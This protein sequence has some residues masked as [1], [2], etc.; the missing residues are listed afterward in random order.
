MIPLIADHI[1]Y[2]IQRV[3]G[4][5]VVWNE[6]MSRARA[7]MDIDLTE[8]DYRNNMRPRRMERYRVPDYKAQAPAIFHSSYFRVLPQEGVRNVTTVHD[9]TYHFYRR[10]LAKAVHLWEE[11]RAL[12]HSDAV[13]CV[14]ENTKRDVLRFYPWVDEEKVH[15][16]YN[17]VSDDFFPISSIKKQ[18]YLLFLG[19]GTAAYKRLDVA[20]EVARLTGLELKLAKQLTREELNRCYNEALCLLYPSDYEGFGL[21]ILEAQKAGC[22]VIAQHTSSVPEV[23]GEGGWM[24]KHDTPQRMAEEMAGLVR[25]LLSRPTQAM[26]EAGMTNAQRFSWDKTYQQTKQIYRQLFES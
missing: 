16:V 1:I 7:D 17:G 14:S 20:Q 6:L 4:V 2:S 3:G 19:N 24:V 23:I 10:G 11:R 26:I 15:V 18:G 13:L 12:H 9:L 21:P 5:S 25:Q 22:P 8:L